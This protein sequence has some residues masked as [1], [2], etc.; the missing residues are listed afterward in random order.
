MLLTILQSAFAKPARMLLAASLSVG[1]VA[2][3]GGGGNPGTV[4]GGDP[5]GLPAKP[6]AS[7]S[8]VASA[9]TISGS[10]VAGSEVTLT[11]VAK[12]AGNNA[13]PGVTISFAA[14]SGTVSSTVRVTDANGAVVEKLS[15][16]GDP[17]PRAITITASSGGAT[18]PAKTV[19]VVAASSVTSKLLLTAAS[20]TL[21]SAGT[22]GSG[23]EIRALV[24]TA[25]NVV[26]PNKVVSFTADSGS[27]SASQ[28][29]TDAT[30]VAVVTLDTAA[31]PTSRVI[32]VT[33]RIDGSPASVVT[34]S[35]V[36]TKLT[37][38]APTSVNQGAKVD[39]TATLTDSAGNPLTGRS[40]TFSSLRGGLTTKTGGGSPALTDSAG[41]L[42]LSYTGTVNGADTISL[43]G[44]GET[45]TVGITTVSTAFTVSVVDLVNGTYVPRSS[46]STDTCNTVLVHDFD[47]A[48]AR[49]GTV[50]VSTSRGTLYSDAQCTTPLSSAVTLSSGEATVYL[51]ATSPGLATLTAN[52]NAAGTSVQGTVDVTAPLTSNATISVQAT[53]AVI[54]ANSTGSSSQQ[55]TL[56]AVVL[57]RATQ[58]NP[59]KN[60]RVA[61]SIVS[62]PSGG[63]LS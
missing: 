9:D 31:D 60:A 2:C 34:V 58:G 30:G 28:K 51:K 48:T 12:D 10:G 21:P 38:N 22:P 53:P 24:L 7:I 45:A 18:S 3:G 6:V 47:G 39:M 5:G 13:M 16:A 62:D 37:M 57:D 41:K 26:L 11:A 15:V 29:S 1:L 49:V 59:V 63:V 52:S 44:L 19:T 36:G 8:L 55:S 61:F 27:L 46:A 14:S 42:V 35:V 56:R 33:A 43:K 23:V 20:G 17:T 25:D 4:N 40:I 50:N 54:G 32:T